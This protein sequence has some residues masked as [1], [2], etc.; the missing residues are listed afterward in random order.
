MMHPIVKYHAAILIIN[1]FWVNGPVSGKGKA[2]LKWPFKLKYDILLLPV[3]TVALQ[4]RSA[5]GQ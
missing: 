1:H 2:W 3:F 5:F 4:L